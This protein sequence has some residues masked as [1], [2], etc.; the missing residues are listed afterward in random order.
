MCRDLRVG[1]AQ[2]CGRR[3]KKDWSINQSSPTSPPGKSLGTRDGTPL[4]KKGRAP[5]SD[6]P[7]PLERAAH[8][9]PPTQPVRSIHEDTESIAA[10]PSSHETSYAPMAIPPST[11]NV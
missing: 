6:A 1:A 8:M 10:T 4:H 5:G 2:T 3:R 11:L 7:C 9:D